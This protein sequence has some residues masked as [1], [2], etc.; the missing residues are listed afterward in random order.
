MNL[1]LY[2]RASIVLVLISML[3]SG[4]RPAQ[5]DEQSSDRAL[6]DQVAILTHAVRSLQKQV[7]ALH[8]LHEHPSTPPALSGSDTDP[9]P[10]RTTAARKATP[11]TTIPVVASRIASAH[12]ATTPAKI[13]KDWHALQTGLD[14][15]AVNGL[16]G[17]P[18][19]SFRLN[20]DN[21][22]WYYDYEGVG[23]GSVM[24][25]ADG[26]VTGWQAPP[27]NWLW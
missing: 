24:F 22:V 16:L 19:R 9:D 27:S 6:R 3:F 25:S 15:H 8:A 10:A 1:H 4:P 11:D 17:P 12:Q 13:R 14:T 7:K 2:D 26:R 18:S 23:V 21:P 5:A 20:G